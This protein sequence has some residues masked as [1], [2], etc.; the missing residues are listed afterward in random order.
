MAARLP[1]AAGCDDGDYFGSA[2]RMRTPSSYSVFVKDSGHINSSHRIHA[3][4]DEEAVEE[5]RKFLSGPLRVEVWQDQRFVARV[6]LAAPQPAL[7][8]Q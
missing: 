7:K 1:R 2:I 6:D 5:A 4:S 3:D 8:S